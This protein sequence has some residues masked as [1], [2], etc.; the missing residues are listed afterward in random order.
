MVV[1]NA[2]KLQILKKNVECTRNKHTTHTTLL[3]HK[4]PDSFSQ[5]N[6][7]QSPLHSFLFCT[8]V[9]HVILTISP[10]HRSVT[11]SLEI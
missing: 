3:F 2:D 6:T 11:F 7:Y 9:H 10:I 4:L 1:Y 5:P 8:S